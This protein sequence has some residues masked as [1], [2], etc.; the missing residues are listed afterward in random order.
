MSIL[1][2]I[3]QNSNP[4]KEIIFLKRLEKRITMIAG[5]NGA[6]K[7]TLAL[8]LV[9]NPK[10]IYEDFLNADQIALGLAPLHPESVNFQA[11]KLMMDRFHHYINAREASPRL[12]I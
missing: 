7:T 6:G 2:I 9:T 11:G 5:P 1:L 4:L 3:R 8:A 12:K 10:E